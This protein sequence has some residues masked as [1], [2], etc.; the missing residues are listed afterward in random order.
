M[1]FCVMVVAALALGGCQS[2]AERQAAETREA[3]GFCSSI[4]ALPGSDAYVRCRLQL[5]AEEA[6]KQ[7]A[8]RDRIAAT[9]DF[10]LGVAPVQNPV[11]CNSTPFLGS[12]RTTCN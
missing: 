7:E 2:A 8:R 3:D 10:K 11:V 12:V 4:G 9:P 5:R 6:A 1:R